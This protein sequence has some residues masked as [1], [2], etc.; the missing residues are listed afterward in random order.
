LSTDTFETPLPCPCGGGTVVV[1][2][3]TPDHP[4]PSAYNTERHIEIRCE[5]CD[6]EYVRDGLSLVRCADYRAQHEANTR[7][8][9]ALHEFHESSALGEVR[10]AF[11]AHLDAMPSMAARHRYLGQHGLDSYSI[12]TFRK[13]WQGGVDWANHHVNARCLPKV[14]RLLGRAPSLF[15]S[16]LQRLRDLDAAIPTVPIVMNCR[17]AMKLPEN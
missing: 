16:E 6:R 2:T 10:A 3:T 4:H 13:H 12:G 17:T 14:L 1:V 11:G 8:R 9:D 7:S 15:D 5:V